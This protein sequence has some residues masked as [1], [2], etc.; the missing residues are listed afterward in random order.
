MK[1][2]RLPVTGA[3][4]D[5]LLRERVHDSYKT[6]L[7]LP[8]PTVCPGC[9]AVYLKGRWTWQAAPDG[10]NAELCQACRRVNDAYPAGVAT[11]TGG[12]VRE[13]RREILNLARNEEALEKGEHP[14]HRIM[15]MEEKHGEIEITT[16][17]IHLPRRIGQALHNAYEGT[18]DLHYDKDGY[19]VRVTW[20]REEA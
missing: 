5:R 12:F 9:G 2:R 8:D 17:D 19:F 14:L 4:G 7:K 18:L 1:K 13:H 10:A 6:R 16:T 11:L 20:T 15:G 3:R